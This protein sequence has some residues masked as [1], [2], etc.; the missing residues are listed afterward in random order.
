MNIDSEQVDN[1]SLRYWRAAIETLTPAKRDAAWEYYVSHFASG[2]CGDTLSALVLLLEANG[3][4]LERL[5]ERY[6]E[7]LISP[8]QAQ[9]RRLQERL[10]EHEGHQREVVATLERA[11]RQNSDASVRVQ[12]TATKVEGSLR[13]AATAVDAQAVVEGIRGQIVD[14]ALLPFARKLD[15]LANQTK[16][17]D[18][19]T[20]SAREAADTWRRLHLR[21]I[22]LTGWG[23]GLVIFAVLFGWGWS[24]LERSEENRFAELR[25]KMAANI[26]D[27]QEA[28][29]KLTELGVSLRVAPVTGSDGNPKPDSFAVLVEP[30]ENAD[31]DTRDGHSRGVVY[32]K[33]VTKNRIFP[34]IFR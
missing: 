23:V 34:S 27:D 29:R 3:V 17:I 31:Y 2:N 24:S 22:V 6:H 4:F 13:D 21:G 8:L 11:A 9:L 33:P 25:V 19:A 16:K 14:G 18:V 7:E 32:L 20:K 5:P 10:A 30:A 15:E 12:A 26:R 1:S 28:L